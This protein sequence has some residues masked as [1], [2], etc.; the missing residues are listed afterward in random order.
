MNP[1]NNLNNELKLISLCANQ[2]T[3]SFNPDPTKQ[4]IQ[5]TFSRKAQTTAHPKI[6]FI[7][8]E[9][10][11]MN[12]QKHLGLTLGTKLIFAS[13]I[14]EKIKKARQGLGILRTLS[15]YL[16]VKTLEQIN[17]GE[18]GR[19]GGNVG[20]WL[21]IEKKHY[22]YYLTILSYERKLCILVQHTTDFISIRTG[23]RQITEK[24]TWSDF[25][26]YHIFSCV[27]YFFMILS[28]MTSK[29]IWLL[30]RKHWIRK[31]GGFEG[32]KVASIIVLVTYL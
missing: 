10:K 17:R 24:F 15:R 32:I 21:D 27:S 29:F 31:F 12:E 5:V 22:Q 18:G 1:A 23:S 20:G 8:I 13:H 30:E 11:T 19:V 14:D 25:S 16:S 28:L 4:A 26:F 9:V 2:C 7:D 6:Y 3:T